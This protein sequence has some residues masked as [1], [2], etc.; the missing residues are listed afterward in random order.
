MDVLERDPVLAQ[1][2]EDHGPLELEPAE[3]EFRRLVIS[4][5]NQQVST[6]SAN[7]IRERVFDRFTIT[8]DG[9]LDAD[10]EELREAGLS[11]QKVEYV[12]NVARAFQERDLT[13]EG[14]SDHSNED[15]IEELTAIRGVGEW[16]AHMYLLFVLGRED[17]LPLGDLAV[18]RGIELLYAD[19]ESLTRA[20]MREI[21]ENWRPYRSVATLYIWTAYESQ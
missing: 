4:I 19:G 18:R 6:A 11:R 8:P 21:A 9:L 14:L 1:L 16:T 20:E 15:V 17:V 7:A 2:I 13:R 12:K 10:P 3:D 5:I